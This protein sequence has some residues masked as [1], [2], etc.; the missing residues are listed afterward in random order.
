[1]AFGD[2]DRDVFIES[3]V[4]GVTVV[5]GAVTT[6][7]IPDTWTE[8]FLDGQVVGQL[9]T[10]KAVRV[11]TG[12]LTPVIGGAIAVD[13]A[14]YTVRDFRLKEPDGRWTLVKLADA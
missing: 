11:K 4:F 14:N 5:S 7:G 9:G 2:A 12:A 6:H 3:A 13:G 8:E 10:H 1:M